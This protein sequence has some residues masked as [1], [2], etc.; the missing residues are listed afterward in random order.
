MLTNLDSLNPGHLSW[1]IIF[2]DDLHNAQKN[3]I[4]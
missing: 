3:P 2:R 1:L 4:N